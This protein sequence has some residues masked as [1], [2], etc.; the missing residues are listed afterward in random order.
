MEEAMQWSA[1][2][3]ERC[4]QDLSIPIVE[5][6]EKYIRNIV[7]HPEQIKFRQLRVAQQKFEQLIW[8]T[9]AR[10][11]VLACGFVEHGAYVELGCTSPLSAN[12]LQELRML[13]AFL[14][15]WSQQ[16]QQQ[17]PLGEQPAGADGHGRAGFG[18]A[19]FNGD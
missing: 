14:T 16:L 19:G 15:T 7:D 11:I 12:R 2:H 1:H 10:G 6:L 13:L 3:T 8:N 9:P 17:E 5:T 4:W 18:R